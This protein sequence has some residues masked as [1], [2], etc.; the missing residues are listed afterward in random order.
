[1]QGIKQTETLADQAFNI[2]KQAITNGTLKEEESLPE[3]KLANNLGISRTPLRDALNRLAA[4]G[5][6]VQQK[7]RPATVASF[8]KEDSL[9]YMELRSLL[10]V[11][12]IEKIMHTVD[13]NF[14]TQLMDNVEKQ[15]ETIERNSYNDFIELDRD[16][17]LLLASRN[18]NSELRKMIHRVNTGVNR[19]FLI[20]SNTVPTSAKD[21]C[22]EHQEI[23]EALKK[24]DVVLARNKMIVHMNNVEKR[25]L[26]YYL[27]ESKE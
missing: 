3:E 27:N 23:I 1:M 10:E 19:A 22:E 17:H 13:E 18:K 4:E 20:L 24:Q 12:N 5:L 21:A 14:I 9:E 2:L 7:G 16:F 8:T 6:V 25:F 11:H 15:R 26:G